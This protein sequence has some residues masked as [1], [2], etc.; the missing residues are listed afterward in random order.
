MLHWFWKRAE[1]DHWESYDDSEGRYSE[2]MNQFHN[3]EKNLE[4]IQ[5]AGQQTEKYA[6]FF[7]DGDNESVDENY[8]P[9]EY[10]FEDEID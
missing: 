4:E 2:N 1:M 9:K 3:D 6:N 8:K 7:G 5:K 10:S